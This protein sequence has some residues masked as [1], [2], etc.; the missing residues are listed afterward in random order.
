MAWGKIGMMTKFELIDAFSILLYDNGLRLEVPNLGCEQWRFVSLYVATY[1]QPGTSGLGTARRYD[2]S[3]LQG[4]LEIP[5]TK[6]LAHKNPLPSSSPAHKKK[7]GFQI[8]VLYPY[9]QGDGEL[10]KSR[11][12]GGYV[13]HPSV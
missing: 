3:A 8:L 10:G 7:E 12:L 11:K 13:P 2:T 6:R 5:C 1:H 4:R 9:H